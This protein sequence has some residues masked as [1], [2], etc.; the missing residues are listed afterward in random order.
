MMISE[1]STQLKFWIE[2]V[3]TK[4][5]H[6]SEEELANKPAPGKWSK[7][8]ILGHLIDSARNNLQRF[9]RAPLAESVYHAQPYPQDDLV[10]LNNYQALP[11]SQILDL[12]VALNLQ[13]ATVIEGIPDSKL[14]IQIHFLEKQPQTLAWWIDDYLKHLEHHLAQIFSLKKVGKINLPENWQISIETAMEKLG[15]EPAG[16]PFITLLKRGEM[17]VEIYK[18]EKVDLQKP[19]DQDEL[20]VVISGTGNFYNNGERSAFQAGDVIFVPAGVEH[21]FENFSEDFKTWVIFY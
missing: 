17:Y 10:R 7:K 8:E 3:P 14:D 18:P 19:H 1:I 4:M 16:K 2:K 6:Y 13:I 15:K 20:Y 9:L 21:R 12:W 11:L 5:W